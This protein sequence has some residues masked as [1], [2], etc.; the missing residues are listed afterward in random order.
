MVRAGD[1]IENP[2]TGETMRF[3]LT[4]AETANELL[5]IEM[6]VRPG[7]FV[8]SEHVHPHQTERFDITSGRITLRV[9]G[10]ERLYA[11]GESITIPPGT[12]HVW[13][14]S[15]TDDLRVTLDFRPA[16]RFADFVT[17][18]FAL[19]MA[20]KTNARGLP[21]DVLQLAVTFA[22]YRNV[23]YGTTPPR[24]VQQVLFAVLAP[25]GRRLGYRPD[26]PYPSLR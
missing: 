12:P 10:E 26:V 1:F 6:V 18:F 2:V 8:A 14:N 22:E 11:A 7:G 19:A 9:E 15:G 21:R 16:G 4:G 3:V 24:A 5:R 25:L 20:G 17:T 23:I 13:W